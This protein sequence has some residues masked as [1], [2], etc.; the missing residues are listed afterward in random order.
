MLED[1]RDRVSH[2]LARIPVTV[3]LADLTSR[4][5]FEDHLGPTSHASTLRDL[6]TSEGNYLLG[7]S[8]PLAS[9]ILARKRP[10]LIPIID[11]DVLDLIDHGDDWST[12]HYALTHGPSL[13]HQLQEI[14]DAS[15]IAD[16]GYAPSTP[17]LMHIILSMERAARRNREQDIAAAAATIQLF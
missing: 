12:W 2:H 4:K 11:Q 14:A 17:R 3:R 16:S 15:G 8:P 5:A 9:T 6:L 13:R 7:I 10:H 1:Q